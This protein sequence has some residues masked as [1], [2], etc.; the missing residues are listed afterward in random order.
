MGFRG[1]TNSLVPSSADGKQ[2]V[3]FCERFGPPADYTLF[4]NLFDNLLGHC[5][6]EIQ[7]MKE[8]LVEQSEE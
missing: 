1:K 3:R 8:N 6:A 7:R 2:N 5:G 4:D